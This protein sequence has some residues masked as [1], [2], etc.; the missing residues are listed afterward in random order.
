MTPTFH[1]K[2]RLQPVPPEDQNRFKIVPTPIALLWWRGLGKWEDF[3]ET[4]NLPNTSIWIEQWGLHS[5]Y[6]QFILDM[7]AYLHNNCYY[8]A[9][10]LFAYIHSNR[11][12]RFMRRFDVMKGFINSDSYSIAI[13]CDSNQF[14][15]TLCWGLQLYRNRI[16]FN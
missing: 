3:V 5:S 4:P 9:D 2:P 13:I 11:M 6:S 8:G 10:Y 1:W 7:T 12:K 16:L 15:R 14:K